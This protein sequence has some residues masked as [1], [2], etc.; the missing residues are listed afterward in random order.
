MKER[1]EDEFRRAWTE[2]ITRTP[3]KIKADIAKQE[4]IQKGAIREA[5]AMTTQ[6]RRSLKKPL[7]FPCKTDDPIL[8]PAYDKQVTKY[9]AAAAELKKLAAELAES[10]AVRA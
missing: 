5:L 9:Y 4:S 7:V 2:D 6:N 1:F 3:E 10:E 8:Q